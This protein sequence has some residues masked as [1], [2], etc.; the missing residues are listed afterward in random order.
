MNILRRAAIVISYLIAGISAIFVVVVTI[1]YVFLDGGEK[2]F[3]V[4]RSVTSPDE[5]HILTVNVSNPST[6][7]GWHAIEVVLT[8][9]ADRNVEISKQLRLFNDGAKI[10]PHNIEIRW[11]DD[12]NGFICLRGAEQEPMLVTVKVR[13]PKIENRTESC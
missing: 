8:G 2:P 6:P 1:S 5:R 12:D 13:E 4:Y 3:S 11:R 9:S 10:E 7:Y